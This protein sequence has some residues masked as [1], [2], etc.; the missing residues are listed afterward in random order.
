MSRIMTLAT[1]LA[2]PAALAVLVAGA[3]G[4][5]FPG[6]SR[7]DVERIREKAQEMEQNLEKH[8]F[9]VD[10]KAATP[11]SQRVYKDYDFLLK[12]SK[13]DELAGAGGT[14]P[15]A[16]RLK[17]FLVRCIV[18]ANLASYE[19]DLKKFEQTS[20][21]NVDG[22]D[23][24]YRDVL[25]DLA[26]AS[27]DSDRRRLYAGLTSQFET[28]A[29]FGKQIMSRRNE[30]LQPWGFKNFAEFYAA[31]ENLDLDG[32]AATADSFL[33]ATQ[34]LYDSLFTVMADRYLH[35]EARKVRFYDLPYLTQGIMFESAFPPAARKARM[36][37]LYRGLGVDVDAQAGLTL[38]DE[39]R[40]GK[41]LRTGVYQAA[42]PGDVRVS[43][44]PLGGIRDDDDYVYGVG[45]AQIFTQSTQT[46]FEAAYLPNQ[47]AQAALAFLPRLVLIEPGWVQA[48]AKADG[49][50]AAQY[51][52]YRAFLTLYEARMLAGLTGFELGVYRGSAD[53]GEDFRKAMET[54]TGARMAASDGKRASEYL[55]RLNS[56]ARFQ[57]L[58]IAAGVQN[59]LRTTLGEDWYAG[60]KAASALKPLWQKGGALTPADIEAACGNAQPDMKDLIHEI[61]SLVVP[62]GGTE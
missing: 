22:K 46:H 54:A 20:T 19:D 51:S 44:N 39:A 8:A 53:M 21:V 11:N 58:L 32:V 16:G 45:A 40:P 3:A 2:R 35:T 5:A 7:A 49:F 27:S 38:D 37:A 15:A 1:G 9:E 17:L 47:T 24:P 30:Q 4:A 57:G 59:H 50:E 25:K 36:K 31:R 55:N 62:A 13:V 12:K 33:S 42:V 43:F 26:A 61:R 34:S 52:T 14:D 41:A 29:V 6:V 60:G 28:I 56:A 23:V 10:A 48:N 18:D